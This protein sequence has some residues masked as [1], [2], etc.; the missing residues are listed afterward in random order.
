MSK[1]AREYNTEVGTMV[2]K[3]NEGLNGSEARLLSA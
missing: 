3:L 2:H 1:K